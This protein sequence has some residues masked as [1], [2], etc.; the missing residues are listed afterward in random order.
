MVEYTTDWFSRSGAVWPAFL[1]KLKDQPVHVL[2]IG[3][4]EGR[5]A[6]FLLNFLPLSR[7]VCVDIFSDDY[8]V[9]FDKNIA[10]FGDRV[11]KIKGRSVPA[12]DRLR[13]DGR[14]FDLIYVDGSH[15]RQDVFSDTVLAWPLLKARGILIWDDWRWGMGKP[16]EARPQHA[17][18]LFCAAFSPCLRVLHRD[19]QVIAEKRREWPPLRFA[20]LRY[21]LA[22][23][24]GKLTGA[25]RPQA[26]PAAPPLHPERA[27]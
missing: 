1:A 24:V 23:E 9:R 25:T 10:P 16:S 12:L 15:E 6:V 19:Y 13:K 14:M 4:Y 2:E 8:E 7:I 27:R 21:R 11:E 26:A 20:S 22:R 18:D 3:S 17:I 5:S